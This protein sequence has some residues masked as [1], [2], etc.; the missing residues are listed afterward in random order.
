MTS[1]RER[2]VTARPDAAP[3]TADLIKR[4]SEEVSRLV[5]DEIRLATLELSRKGRRARMGAGMFGGAAACAL[6]GAGALVA[7]VIMLLA[8]VLTPWIAAAVVGVVLL[9]VAGVLAL[10]GKGQVGRATPPLPQ[11]AMKSIR[12]DVDA[13]KEGAHR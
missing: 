13:V 10:A 5:R 12:A 7:A 6:Y 9:V 1:L 11:E 3:T 8:T 4:L 2:D